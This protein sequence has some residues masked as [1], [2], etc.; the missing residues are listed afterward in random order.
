MSRELPPK[1]PWALHHL[2]P[3]ASPWEGW[4]LHDE[5]LAFNIWEGFTT[6][7]QRNEDKNWNDAV[8]RWKSFHNGTLRSGPFNTHCI[9]H[10]PLKNWC[11]Q[12]QPAPWLEDLPN[13]VVTTKTS[14]STCQSL[15]AAGNRPI[16]ADC[17][18][19]IDTVSGGGVVGTH[20]HFHEFPN[21]KKEFSIHLIILIVVG[22]VFALGLTLRLVQWRRKRK[23]LE[24]PQDEDGLYEKT[25]A[26]CD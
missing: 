11:T 10:G 5:V 2:G 20:K 7:F 18:A 1:W 17:L 4:F 16:D 15:V 8:N 23:L 12:P 6:R 26:S 25:Q 21:D 3:P 19:D 14:N 9:G 22:G 24:V 13:C